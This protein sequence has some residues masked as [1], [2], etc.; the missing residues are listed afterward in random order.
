MNKSIES[1]K[2]LSEIENLIQ[3]YLDEAKKENKVPT[4][5]EIIEAVTDRLEK[6]LETYSGDKEVTYIVSGLAVGI[7][8]VLEVEELLKKN[9]PLDIKK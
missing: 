4:R 5:D 1:K 6:L 3:S 9:E 8:I 2:I 7:A